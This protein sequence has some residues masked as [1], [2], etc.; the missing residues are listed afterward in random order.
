MTFKHNQR[1]KSLFL[2]IVMLFISS[3]KFFSN[4]YNEKIAGRYYS[5]GILFDENE[6]DKDVTYSATYETTEDFYPEN[7]VK[8]N[9]IL[10]FT[11]ITDEKKFSLTYQLKLYGKWDI[12]G[13]KLQY[14]YD[15]N[16][17]SLEYIDSDF[18]ASEI[19]DFEEY[20]TQNLIV[21]IKEIITESERYPSK[22]VELNDDRL[23]LIDNEK[24]EVVMKRVQIPEIAIE[25]NFPDD[26]VTF[27]NDFTS[28][29]A[30]QLKLIKFP[31]SGT[32][33]AKTK[34]TWIFVRRELIFQGDNEIDGVE[35][36]GDFSIIDQNLIEYTMGITESDILFSMKF[37]KDEIGWYLVSYEEP[38]YEY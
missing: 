37:E 34:N 3:C 31:I 25:P 10:V 36:T 18:Q 23:V 22:I 27:I 30:S 33:T 15:L 19:A 7:R 5:T 13:D 14:T 17:I 28:N 11:F 6:I 29:K 8:E 35:Y 20:F 16:S 1:I 26:F 4:N 12:K 21:G 2:L 38:N 24:N 32:T 9:T